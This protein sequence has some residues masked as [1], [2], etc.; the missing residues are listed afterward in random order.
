MARFLRRKVKAGEYTDV[1]E[2]VRDAVRRLQ[3]IEAAKSELLLLAE[4]ESHWL[5]SGRE[6]VRH[7]VEQGIEDIEAGR[8][9]EYDTEGLRGLATELVAQAVKKQNSRSK[10][11]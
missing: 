4:R 1:S 11:E 9:E 10:P 2:V 7:A 5:E 8:F 3:A 6:D